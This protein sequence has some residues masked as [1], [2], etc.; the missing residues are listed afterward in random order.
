MHSEAKQTETAEFG[1]E[2]GLF[3]VHARIQVV[4]DPKYPKLPKQF[5]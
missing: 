4:Y 1:A 5:L 2:K 3:Q